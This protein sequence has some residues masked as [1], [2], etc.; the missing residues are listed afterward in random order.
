MK[1][2]GLSAIV[3]TIVLAA[4]LGAGSYYLKS[5]NTDH[6][7]DI[8]SQLTSESPS[9]NAATVTENKPSALKNLIAN[10]IKKQEEMTERKD[11]DNS[12]LE[13]ERFYTDQEIADMTEEEFTVLVQEIELKFPKLSDIKK[14]P[15]G[16][17]H[18]TPA[19]VL[20]AGKELGLLKEILKVHESYERVAVG[21][22]ERCAKSA[23]RPTPV[24]ALCLTNLVTTKKKNSEKVNLKEYPSELVEL[25]RMITDL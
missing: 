6:S 18:R 7:N 4:L 16:A 22:Y 5:K 13:L 8:K 3:T 21:F 10:T 19:P 12:V 24:R 25:T 23:E 17:L 1:L 2:R 14:L 11:F 15:P 9:Q 20:Q